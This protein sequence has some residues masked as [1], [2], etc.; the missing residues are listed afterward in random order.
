[1]ARG[2][3]RIYLGAA[4]GVGK[5]YAMLD[6]GARRR[7]RQTDVVIGVVETHGRPQTAA[8]AAGLE[9]VPPRLGDR[10]GVTVGELDLDRVIA[11]RPQVVL[12]DDLAHTNAPGGRH[13]KRWQDVD[14]LLDAGIDVIATV[15]VQHLDSLVDVVEQITGTAEPDTVP[16][17]FV[18]HADQIELVDMSPEALRRRLAHGNVYPADAVDAALA[19]FFRPGNLAALRELALLWV[20]DRVEDA[21]QVYLDDHGITRT[22]ETRERVVV[23]LTGSPSGDRLVRRAARIAG[24]AHGELFGVH[25]ARPD[26]SSTTSVH[27]E[28]QRALLGELGGTYREV[29]STDVAAALAAFAQAEQATQV[30]LGATRRS[31]ISQL[32]TG[33]VADDLQRQLGAVDVHI[34][35]SEQHPSLAIVAA[36]RRGRRL[37]AIPARRERLAWATMILGIPLLTFAVVHLRAHL[38]LSSALL[39]QLAMVLFISALGGLRPGVFA[40]VAAFLLTNWYLTLPVHTLSIADTD[41]LIALSVFIA[42]AIAVSALVDRS[43]RRSREALRARADATALARSTGSIIAADDPMPQLVDQLRTLFALDAVSVMTR[44]PSGWRVAAASGG[45]PPA[46]PDDGVAISLDDTGDTQLVLRGDPVS[47]DELQVLRAFAD[48]MSLGLEAHRLRQASATIGALSEANL[49][50]AALLQAVSHDLRT[51]LASI[52]ASV[53][54]LMAGDVGFSAED[55]ASLLDTIDISA[56]RLDRVVGNLLDMSRL[57]AG[58]TRVTL[59]ATPLEEVVAAALGGIDIP[60]DRLVID[61]SDSLPMVLTDAALL[62]RA[63]ANLVSNAL[64]WSPPGVPVRIDAAQVKGHLQLR[65][66]DRGPGIPREE[67]ARIFEPFQ[68]LGDRSTD[69]GVG[70]GLA[71]ARRFVEVT[72]GTLEVDDTPGGGTTFT[73]RIPMAGNAHDNSHNNDSH[74]ADDLSGSP[75]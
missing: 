23:A 50:R 44:E 74:D 27:L 58:A 41:D 36:Q 11:R 68:R 26:Q 29:V 38:N 48:Q 5:T 54:G 62:E 17:S 52:K 69:A 72:G 47:D 65:V 70:L 75:T 56:D 6:E 7:E 25:V 61:V 34:I 15:N 3:L 60:N 19:D 33:S 37:T 13:A 57:Q 49:L 55:R 51:P 71:I 16:D 14:E 4:P 18:R 10:D 39:L 40:S 42:V 32:L 64:V 8:R 63:V 21:L 30:V 1:M 45:T 46:T 24:R 31:R 20:A 9:I 66:V 67:R 59:V 35:A 12:V 28:Q 2:I 53:T 43:A 22:W 73:I